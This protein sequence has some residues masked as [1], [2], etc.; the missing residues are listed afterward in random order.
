MPDSNLPP[1]DQ[2]EEE[3]IEVMSCV[4][5]S[6]RVAIKR[7]EDVSV[8]LSHIQKAKDSM[9]ANDYEYA[10]TFALEAEKSIGQSLEHAEKKEDQSSG[11][12]PEHDTPTSEASEEGHEHDLDFI[13]EILEIVSLVIDKAR[14][15]GLDVSKAEGLEDQALEAWNK[16][17]IDTVVDISHSIKEEILNLQR[18]IASRS[19]EEEE[20]PKKEDKKKGI[21][22]ALATIQKIQERLSRIKGEGVDISSAEEIFEKVDTSLRERRFN[23]AVSLAK[24]ADRMALIANGEQT[25]D[26]KEEATEAPTA[27]ETAA[28]A[29]E[30]PEFKPTVPLPTGDESQQEL[31]RKAIMA[32]RAA[33][34]AIEN[35]RREGADTSSAEEAFKHAESALIKKD[36]SLLLQNTADA[37]RYAFEALNKKK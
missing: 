31:N 37:E 30:A 1:D 35:A 16:K 36:F 21:Q 12:P 18:D 27:E 17:D 6:I 4:R 28:P 10:I 20:E 11:E 3:I 23:E 19:E 2:K 33:Q 26:A 32:I 29:P 24:K 7:K 34:G 25:E 5:D 9:V 8:A 13:V 15:A 22:E 14:L